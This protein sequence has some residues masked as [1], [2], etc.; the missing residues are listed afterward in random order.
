[1]KYEYAPLDEQ[2][3]ES[4]SWLQMPLRSR[5]IESRWRTTCLSIFTHTL[6]FVAGLLAYDASVFVMHSFDNKSPFTMEQKALITPPK[7]SATKVIDGIEVAGTQC[8]NSWQEAKAMGCKY[9]IIAS[10]WYAPECFDGEV[11]ENMLE[12]PTVNFTW[13]ADRAHTIV[14]PTEIVQRGEFEM[15]FPDNIFHVK[16]CLHLWRKLH[17]AIVTGRSVDEDIME[18]E[19]TVHCTVLIMEWITPGF[20]K[21]SITHSKPGRPF[22]RSTKLGIDAGK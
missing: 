4:V 7:F 17:H 21:T 19:H 16:H 20:V 11:L 15:V 8:G 2:G 6:M 22:C 10:A 3:E 13:Y 9:D 5:K 18:Y 1:M 12:E 14:V